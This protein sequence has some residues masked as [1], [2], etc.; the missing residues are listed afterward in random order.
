MIKTFENVTGLSANPPDLGYDL[1]RVVDIFFQ[2]NNNKASKPRKSHLESNEH[3]CQLLVHNYLKS[4]SFDDEAKEL[5]NI[6]KF[7]TEQS[8]GL[9]L[10]SVC[11][12]HI[13]T[14]NV[15][16]ILPRRETRG[17]RA[18]QLMSTLPKNAEFTATLG[19]RGSVQLTYADYDYCFHGENNGM[20]RWTCRYHGHPLCKGCS[21]TIKVCWK[22]GKVMSAKEHSHPSEVGKKME[23][24]T[25]GTS[26]STIRYSKS[27]RGAPVLHYQGYEYT[28]RKKAGNEIIWYCRYQKPKK[29]KGHLHTK[30][31]V[32]IGN[33]REHS[34]LP[35]DTNPQE[36]E[37]SNKMISPLFL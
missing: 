12:E 22:S 34:H 6:L 23:V 24:S 11:R 26:D 31:G 1:E 13:S 8:A 33:V 25:M 28:Q 27:Q 15:L 14:E 7:D 18:E 37:E 19:A 29:C 16:T 3:L 30:A 21:G 5:K 17:K 2:N 10:E 9:D 32:V 20:I 4:N 36:K 35:V